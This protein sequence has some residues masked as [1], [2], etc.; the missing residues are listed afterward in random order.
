MGPPQGE[1]QIDGED[2]EVP[3][4]S[5][6]VEVL[7]DDCTVVMVRLHVSD[8]RSIALDGY[9]HINYYEDLEGDCEYHIFQRCFGVN[10]S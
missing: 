2:G 4:W 10:L 3:A 8:V 6:R 5:G 9:E 1:D 7:T